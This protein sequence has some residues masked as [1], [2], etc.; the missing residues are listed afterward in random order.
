MADY[1]INDIYQGGYSSLNPKYGNVFTGYRV[2]PG[3]FGL[4]T[5]PRTANVLQDASSKLATG[6]KQIEIT[7][8]SPETFES[9]PDTQLKELN[10]LSKLTG[11]DMSLHA[12]IVEPSGL[13]K[14]GFSDTNREAVERQ[15]LAVVERGHKLNPD[16]NVPITFHSSAMLPE[17]VPAKGKEAEE[18]LVINT[19]TG[20]INKIPIKERFFPGEEGR[21]DVTIELNKINEEQWDENLRQL[22][23]YS[24]IGNERIEKSMAT[25]ILAEAEKNSGK[26]L[27]EEKK[28]MISMF[29][30]GATFLNSSYDGLKKIFDTALNKASEDDRKKIL[31]FYEDIKPKVNQINVDVKSKESILLRKEIIDKGIE[32]L[33]D[34]SAP[35]TYK[36]LNEFSKDK[37]I[38]TFSNVAFNSYKKFKDKSPII[39][40]ENPPVGGAFGRGEDLKNIVEKAR[41]KFVEKA[42][43]E[44]INEKQ[45][46]EAAAKLIGVTWDV[47]HINM[48]RKYGYE[49]KDI[50]KET[51]KVAP[52]VKHVH[53]SDNFGFEHTELP[54]GMGNVPM[55]EIMEKLGKQGFDA[56]KIIEAG[57]WWQHFRTAPF[58]ETLEAFSSPL[59]SM[60]M[61][62]YWD[63]SAGFQQDYYGG[64]GMMLPQTHYETFGAGFSR[65]PMELG[66]QQGG[67]QGGRMSGR[68]ME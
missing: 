24:D 26:E 36:D 48:L 35:Q 47:G 50:I 5:D 6:A 51:E 34:I 58:K 25:A 39:S 63:Q 40:I 9:I 1:T 65:L 41:E 14:E 61:A 20:S 15:M 64:Y 68:P 56:K 38:E 21:R 43:K 53:L 17:Q 46:K 2:N 49:A 54:M 8:I 3:S 52:F 10:R 28:H 57:N 27:S 23:Y 30:S 19:E 13:T 37:T 22:A 11:V 12:P 18:T 66:G 32:T 60:E 31:K 16:G 59:Y 33:G 7:G 67:A 55:K 44:G 29:N 45:A 62:P 42:K 4:T